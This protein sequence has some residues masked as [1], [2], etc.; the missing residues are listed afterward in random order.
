MAVL[1]ALFILFLFMITK[2]KAFFTFISLTAN[3]AVLCYALNLNHKGHNI[4]V[5][6]ICLALFFTFFSLILIS[7]LK[8]KTFAAI[9][10]TLISLSFTMIL[11]KI[12]MV[13]T[14][15]VDYTYMG[16]IAG[17][18]YLSDLFLS[19]I[20]I[21]GLGA[22]MDIAITEAS[23][24]NELVDINSKISIKD[25]ISSGREVGHDIMGTMINIMLFTYI[26]GIIPL[27]I[28]KMKNNIE[29]HTII[30]WQVPMELYGFMIGSIGILLTIPISLTVSIIVF[31][32]LRRSI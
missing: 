13:F 2:K 32:K 15:G 7:G 27:I 9:L 31:K 16:Y 26:C 30:I 4:W 1:L 3:I 23:A 24:I 19:Q 5:I 22:I 14:Q 6:S 10:S 18:N 8:K 20:L 11:F 17:Q 25:L 12:F 29:L 28:L 21:G